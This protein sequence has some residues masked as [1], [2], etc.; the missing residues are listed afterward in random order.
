MVAVTDTSPDAST[1]PMAAVEQAVA[2]PP[3]NIG[4]VPTASMITGAAIGLV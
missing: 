3:R 1:A 4:V 2:S